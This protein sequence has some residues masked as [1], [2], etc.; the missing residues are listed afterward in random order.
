[1][2]DSGFNPANLPPGAFVD[3]KIPAGFAP[4]GIQAI[5]GNLYVT[6]AKQDPD[7]H[8]DVAG[9]GLGYVDVFDPNGNLIDRFVSKGPL[10][11]PWGL[12]LAPAGFGEF[13]GA[14]LVGN[15]HDEFGYINDFDPDTGDFLGSLTG[16][17]GENIIIPYLW[18]MMFGNGATGGDVDDLYF[19]AGIGDELHGLFGEIDAVPV[20]A[21][22]PLLPGALTVLAGYRRRRSASVQNRALR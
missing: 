3:P 11:A 20:P 8:D 19:T 21:A 13:S 18:A 2:W 7:R 16:E 22:F 5:N 12:A 1:M 17:D 15:F 6:Y 10:N 4:F 14:L 9:K